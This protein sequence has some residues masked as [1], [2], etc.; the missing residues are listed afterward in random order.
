MTLWDICTE[1]AE[2]EEGLAYGEVKFTF[3]N[4]MCAIKPGHP[5]DLL[6]DILS[7]IGWDVQKGITPERSKLEQVLKEL[8]GF[9]ATFKI[10]ELGVPIKHLK[11]YLDETK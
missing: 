8:K 3:D 5:A 7:E 2:V 10:K 1:I 6:D 9:K 11:E 4:L